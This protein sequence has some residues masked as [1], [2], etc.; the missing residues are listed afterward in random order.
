[1]YWNAEVSINTYMF[2]FFVSCL[3]LA[4]GVIDLAEFAFVQSYITMQLIEYFVWSKKV[5]SNETISIIGLL[6]ILM[7]PALSI[8]NIRGDY[9]NI[10]PYL[11]AAYFTFVIILLTFIKP[12]NT[13]KFRTSPGPN[14]HLAWHWLDFSLMCV[15]IWMF[16]FLIRYFL[17]SEYISLML[18]S[19]LVI[20]TYVVYQNT[21]E[22][23][24]LWCWLA[25]SV[26]FYYLY[27][28]FMKSGMF[29]CGK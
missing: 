18:I 19:A 25:N 11:L 15:A 8:V 24:S 6:F 16:F 14:G 22:F 29:G 4:N 13:I 10:I 9:Q 1:M 20:S 28:V 3:A 21:L 23:G 5:F 7:Q 27:L 17:N 2:S 26:A 12:W